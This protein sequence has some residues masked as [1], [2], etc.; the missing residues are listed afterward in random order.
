[1]SEGR[2]L[3]LT[4]LE[5]ALGRL[6]QA[7]ADFQAHPEL[8]SLEDGQRLDLLDAFDRSMLLIEVD[9]VDMNDVDGSFR[10]RIEPDLL[11]LQPSAQ[12]E[13]SPQT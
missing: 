12:E 3:D 10:S 11:Q 8:E 6:W 7:L 2:R 4:L 9:V 5:R 1:M 13:G